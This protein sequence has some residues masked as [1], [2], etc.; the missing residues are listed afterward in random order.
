ME[1]VFLIIF[2]L[3]IIPPVSVF[4]KAPKVNNGYYNRKSPVVEVVERVGGSVVNI[5]TERT[6]KERVNPFG[7]P[8]FDRFFSNFFDSYP[9]RKYKQ[10]SLGSGVI[11]SEDGYIL[12]NEH[13]ILKASEIKVTLADERE[14]DAELVGADSKSDL[15]VI[16]IKSK[17]VFPFTKM[18]N[19]EDLMIGE[20][21]IAI[22]N[23]FGLSHTVTT[24]VVS[25]LNRSVK[26][27]NDRVYKDF[28]QTDASIN[29]GNSGGPLL[30]ING[31]LIGINTAIY[32]EA[33]GIGFAIPISRA[34]RI[35]DDLIHYGSVHKAWLGISVQNI[36][37][38]L[39]RYFNLEKK[40]GVII[41]KIIKKSAASKVGLKRGDIIL[42]MGNHEVGS[43]EDYISIIS[44]YTA[45]DKITI[46]IIRDGK[47]KEFTIISQEIPPEAGK[48]LAI[49]WLGLEVKSI[50]RSIALR[51]GIEDKKGVIITKVFRGSVSHRTGLEKGDIIRQANNQRIE[52]EEKFYKIMTMLAEQESVL[53]LIQRGRYI[54]PLTIQP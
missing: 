41:T 53:L 52:N 12:T 24:G 33:E 49:D 8:F 46:L 37:D 50:D 26:I 34:K 42:K 39:V 16:K 40:K 51:Y 1:H 10:Q 36:D 22:G 2:Y 11:I 19:S 17:T 13:V 4:A 18:G 25:A 5:S 6:V 29:P 27:D 20:S 9:Q 45:D 31:A 48:E 15:A 14:F 38:D 35:V 7:D 43:R 44:G 21:V 30:N 54:Y 47:Q 23:P 32:Q 3:F 28:I